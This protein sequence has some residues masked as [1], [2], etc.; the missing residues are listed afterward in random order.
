MSVLY[1]RDYR[2]LTR[3]KNWLKRI[4]CVHSW[5][6]CLCFLPS[7]LRGNFSPSSLLFLHSL[8]SFFL[9]LP[10]SR[11]LYQFIVKEIIKDTVARWRGTSGDVRKGPQHRS[12]YLHGTGYSTLPACECFREPRS[13]L[14]S[15]VLIY[16][17]PSASADANPGYG[18]PTVP[19]Y[20][21]D[22]GIHGALKPTPQGTWGVTAT[23]WVII[24]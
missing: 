14:P 19:F 1:S 13:F 11:S 23:P 4:S 15:V 9:S 5:L 20:M 12:F 6:F 21:R 24:S 2:L 16:T 7:W 3:N 22:L 18:G 17:Q 8:P 10:R